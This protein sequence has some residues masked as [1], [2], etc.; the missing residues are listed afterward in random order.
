MLISANDTNI[1]FATKNPLKIVSKTKN[2]I[3]KKL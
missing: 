3:K 1:E 2:V